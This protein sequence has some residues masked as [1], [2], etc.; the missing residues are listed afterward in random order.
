MAILSHQGSESCRAG[1][2]ANLGQ[3]LQ[4]QSQLTPA[5]THTHLSLMVTL[6]EGGS[7]RLGCWGASLCPAED[8]RKSCLFYYSLSKQREQLRERV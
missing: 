4:P 8:K 1:A 2:K 5:Q 3:L 7:L 6:N